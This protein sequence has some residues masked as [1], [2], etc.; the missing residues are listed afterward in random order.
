MEWTQRRGVA[1]LVSITGT[2]SAVG[3]Q[4]RR[5]QS[6]PVTRTAPR[7]VWPLSR[8]QKEARGGQAGDGH[9]RPKDSHV[10]GQNGGGWLGLTHKRDE[11][12]LWNAD[13]CLVRWSGRETEQEEASA[14]NGGPEKGLTL[15]RGL[16]F[17]LRAPVGRAGFHQPSGEQA[18]QS[19]G[20]RMMTLLL[21]MC[22]LPYQCCFLVC[23]VG[24]ATAPQA[25][26]VWRGQER[27][28]ETCPAHRKA[29]WQRAVKQGRKRTVK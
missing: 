23:Q 18:L 28:L 9:R 13:H 22:L 1:D 6:R 19:R 8:D 17:T 2:Q 12:P 14:G 4:R 21:S 29:Q 16:D 25:H 10:Q 20:L 7:R 5:I 11:R 15:V 26:R 3:T 24:T 27:Q